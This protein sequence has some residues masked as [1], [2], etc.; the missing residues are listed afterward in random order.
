ML[1]RDPEDERYPHLD[2][3]TSGADR[4]DRGR[5]RVYEF[6]G[7]NADGV[8]LKYGRHFAFIDPDGERWD[9]AELM[10]MATPNGHE[11]PWSEDRMRPD[12][13]H[14]AAFELWD[15]LPEETKAWFELFLVL[16]YENIVDVDESG[17]EFFKGPHILVD[18]FV[19]PDGPF[20]DGLR[21]SLRTKDGWSSRWAEAD[22]SKRVTK[23]ARESIRATPD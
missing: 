10:N 7:C 19:K 16:P 20:R 22:E 5:W 18:T 4:F 2:T 8:H 9:Y 21:V 1:V 3:E 6:A 12:P 11:D 14:S 17:D 23:F 15:P 13:D